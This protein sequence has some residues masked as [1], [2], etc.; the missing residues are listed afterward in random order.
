MH[1]GIEVPIWNLK[2]TILMEEWTMCKKQQVGSIT[3][4]DLHNPIIRNVDRIWADEL[5][6][7]NAN[8]MLDEATRIL[9]YLADVRDPK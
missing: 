8:L 4:V 7:A 1:C 9:T 2:L 6:G 3:F 5:F